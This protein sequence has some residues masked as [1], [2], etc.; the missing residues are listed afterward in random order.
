MS[1]AKVDSK[2]RRLSKMK[3]ENAN[4]DKQMVETVNMDSVQSSYLVNH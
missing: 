4:D 1:S 2:N 3:I